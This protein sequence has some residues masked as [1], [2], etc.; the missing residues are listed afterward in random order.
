MPFDPTLAAIRFG[1]GLSPTL[2]SPTSVD[3]MLALLTGP[4][5]AAG[6]APIDLFSGVSPSPTA[7]A[8]AS[9]RLNEARGTDGEKAARDHRR[10]ARRRHGPR[11]PYDGLVSRTSD[12]RL[13]AS[14]HGSRRQ[15]AQ[16]AHGFALDR[17]SH[18]PSS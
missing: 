7:F 16:P 8:D 17:G 2:A 1:M 15:Q 9:R 5:V 12:A 10:V 6:F 4:D 11:R 18:P 14:F 3:E 13:G